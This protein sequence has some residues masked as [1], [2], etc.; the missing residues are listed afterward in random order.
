MLVDAIDDT[1]F[2]AITRHVGPA[3]LTAGKR[4]GLRPDWG[5]VATPRP[6]PFHPLR[7]PPPRPPTTESP[8]SATPAPSGRPRTSAWLSSSRRSPLGKGRW[9]TFNR[10]YLTAAAP[11][12]ST[13]TSRSALRTQ[14]RRDLRSGDEAQMLAILDDATVDDETALWGFLGTAVLRR[15]RKPAARTRSATRSTRLP[16]VAPVKR[17]A[18]EW[19]AIARGV[20]WATPAWP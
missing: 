3:A 16:P 1:V 15:R 5:V 7:R 14:P 18:T 4:R 6:H 19:D 12:T 9:A 10:D 8:C 11:G 17:C 13:R 2:E 20:V